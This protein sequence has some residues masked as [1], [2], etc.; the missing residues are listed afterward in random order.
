MKNWTS[1][2][3]GRS[4]TCPEVGDEIFGRNTRQFQL[5]KEIYFPSCFVS[6]VIITILRT[7]AL[8]ADEKLKNNFSP[9]FTL[10]QYFLLCNVAILC[11]SVFYWVAN[12]PLEKIGL[13]RSF[14]EANFSLV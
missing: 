13:I 9:G 1:V 8:S 5:H 2:L 7:L 10:I 6:V 4:N 12:W 3:K 11:V 14:E